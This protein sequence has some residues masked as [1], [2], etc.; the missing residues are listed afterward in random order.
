MAW[1]RPAWTYCGNWPRP[2]A[3]WS[4]TCSRWSDTSFGEEYENPVIVRNDVQRIEAIKFLIEEGAGDRI[5]IAHDV[6][7]KA[8]YARYGGKSYDHILTNIVP[9]LRRRGFSQ[10]Q[11]DAILVHSPARILPFN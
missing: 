2:A 10:D 6:C 7:S 11:I 5:L 4:L 8:Q 1:A 3:S 9:R